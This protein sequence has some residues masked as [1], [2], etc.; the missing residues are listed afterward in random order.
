MVSA[1]FSPD[2]SLLAAQAALPSGTI[3][4]WHVD[5]GQVVLTLEGDEYGYADYLAFLPDGTALAVERPGELELWSLAQGRLLRTLPVA[6]GVGPFAF[7]PDGALLA[8]GAGD[9]VELRRVSDGELLATLV[10]HLGWVG[11]VT[12]SPDGQFLV[13]GAEDGTVRLWGVPAEGG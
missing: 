12:F 5:S 10:A 3:W 11:S 1:T 7:S 4:V 13:T 9:R 8:L 6:A 2:G